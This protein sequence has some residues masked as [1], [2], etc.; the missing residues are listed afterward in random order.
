MSYLKITEEINY[1]LRI[2]Q[3]NHSTNVNLITLRKN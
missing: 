1:N 3:K 2:E